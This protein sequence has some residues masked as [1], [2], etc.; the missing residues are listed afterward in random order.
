MKGHRLKSDK[1]ERHGTG[2]KTGAD[3][4][5]LTLVSS[6]SKREVDKNIF[7]MALGLQIDR[8]T[9]TYLFGCF[10]F[11]YLRQGFFV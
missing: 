5:L 6:P 2:S 3:L 9:F 11:V 10:G 4:L 8:D 7:S 1:G